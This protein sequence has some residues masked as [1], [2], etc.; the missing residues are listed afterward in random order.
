MRHQGIIVSAAAVLLVGILPAKVMLNPLR[1]SEGGVQKWL[2]A[3]TPLGSTREQVLV[4]AAKRGWKVHPEYRG[5][6]INKSVPVGGFGAEL[7]TYIGVSD[8]KVDAYWRFSV[9][10]KLVEVYVNKWREGF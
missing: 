3:Q 10:D 2:V 1:R 5:R 7:G 9:T 4:V 8:T 6:F